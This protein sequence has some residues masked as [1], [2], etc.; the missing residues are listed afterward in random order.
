MEMAPSKDIL[1]TQTSQKWGFFGHFGQSLKPRFAT[2]GTHSR[3]PPLSFLLKLYVT[4][5]HTHCDH[6]P[7][8]RPNPKHHDKSMIVAYFACACLLAV[9]AAGFSFPGGG[10]VDRALRPDPPPKGAQLTGPKKYPKNRP[11]GRPWFQWRWYLCLRTQGP[12]LIPATCMSRPT[13]A[14]H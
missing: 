5:F 12:R 7:T 2:R 10:G 11:R 9:G 1:D 8:C 13:M 6:P 4:V 14:S 3:P